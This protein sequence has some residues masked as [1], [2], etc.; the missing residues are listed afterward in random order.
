[1]RHVTRY[2]RSGDTHIAYQV[3]GDGPLDLVFVMGWVS[4]LDYLWEGP[5]ARFLTRLASFSRLIL[6][7]KRGTGLSDRVAE[8]PSIEQRMDDVRAVMD[9][10]GS[11]RAALLGISEGGAMCAIFA[12]T[13]PER[14]SALVL[15]GAY[16]KRLRTADYPWAPTEEQRAE[17]L[18]RIEQDWGGPV[19]IDL[20]APSVANDEQFRQWWATYLQRSASP[21]AAATL[22]RTNSQIDIRHV[23]P[24]IRVPTLIIHRSGDENIPVGGARYMAKHIPDA[25][26]VELPGI[27]HLVFAG[28]QEDVLGEIEQFLT[29]DRP[30]AEPDSVLATILLTEIV[31]AVAVAARLGARAWAEALDAHE[32]MMRDEIARFRGREVST[33]AAGVVATFDGPAR[34]VRC[35][36][37]IVEQARGAGLDVR[38]GLHTG[39][40]EVMDGEVRGVASRIAALILMQ[41][42]RGTVVVS[43]TIPDLLAGSG[44]TFHLLDQSVPTGTGRSLRLYQVLTT[45]DPGEASGRGSAAPAAR[46]AL[47]PREL[48]VAR[49]VALGQSNRQIADALF[50]SAATVERHVANIFTKLDLRSRT[51]L[52][53]WVAEHGLIAPDQS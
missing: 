37:S 20:L 17:I 42:E 38:A 51:Q 8:L 9:A 40:C 53:V 50:I 31:G 32:R 48:E 47:T 39:E 36:A 29:G 30:I 18:R 6:F 28:N 45:R 52:G 43:S 3:V 10:A 7:D 35:A 12:A 41:A 1:M 14:T 11:E 26:L 33:T 46:G 13:Y 4:N 49:L 24:A 2:A 22:S 15:Y 23:L 25:R 5:S 21:G 27:D 44:I 34:A 16:A 19:N